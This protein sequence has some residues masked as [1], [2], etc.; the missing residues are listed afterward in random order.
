MRERNGVRGVASDSLIM[1]GNR[2]PVEGLMVGNKQVL[3]ARNRES[4]LLF[5]TLEGGGEL[6]KELK[7]YYTNLT[8]ID[9]AAL[10]YKSR[11]VADR[12]QHNEKRVDG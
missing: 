10:N 4:S 9:R 12:R 8:A 5:L 1:G 2:M 6:P 11:L 7:G 3:V